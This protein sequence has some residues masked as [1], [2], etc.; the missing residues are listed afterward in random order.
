[1]VVVKG[2][3][4]TP[5]GEMF[6]KPPARGLSWEAEIKQVFIIR[7]HLPHNAGRVLL[8]VVEL[9]PAALQQHGQY[10]RLGGL[11]VGDN[12]PFVWDFALY[13]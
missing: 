11:L 3:A 2:V 4:R 8:L 13:L 12:H 10:S 6:C 9:Q 5:A 1:M 7:W